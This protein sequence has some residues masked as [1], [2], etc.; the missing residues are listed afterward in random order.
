MGSPSIRRGPALPEQ[1]EAG[2]GLHWKRLTVYVG[3][4]P[5][6]ITHIRSQ[7]DTCEHHQPMLGVQPRVR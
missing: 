5:L 4:Q 1:G 3:W 2:E 7:P 6:S